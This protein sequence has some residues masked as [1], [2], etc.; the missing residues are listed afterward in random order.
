MKFFMMFASGLDENAC[1]Q[2]VST[3]ENLQQL[4]AS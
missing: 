4:Q 1:A 2:I 3:F